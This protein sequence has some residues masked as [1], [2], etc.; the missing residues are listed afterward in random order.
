LRTDGMIA[1]PKARIPEDWP[2][3]TFEVFE[4]ATTSLRAQANS[5]GKQNDRY[6]AAYQR[7]RIVALNEDQDEFH[8]HVH[9]NVDVRALFDLLAHDSEVA[10]TVEIDALLCETL[11]S[12]SPNFTTLTLLA[13]IQCFFANFQNLDQDHGL[14][15]L[16][17]RQL[18]L[19]DG[20]FGDSE[21]A[22]LDNRKKTIFCS[23]GPVNLVDIATGRDWPFAKFI[24]AFGLRSYDT[25]PYVK[26]CRSLYYLEALKEL[27]I[28]E[29]NNSILAE[30]QDPEVFGAPYEQGRKIGHG[31]IEI[32]LEKFQEIPLIEETWL[33]IILKIA[34]DPRV[35]KG[36]RLYL[37]WWA[38]HSQREIDQVLA[39]LS[40]FDLELFLTAL[41]DYAEKS[42]DPELKRMFTAREVFL[43]GLLDHGLVKQS[44]MFLGKEAE[45]Y[46]KRNYQGEN[47]PS[48]S[49]LGHDTKSIIYLDLGFCKIIEGSHSCYFWIY[50]KL[51]S[52]QTIT[53]FSKKRFGYRE[54]TSTMGEQYCD[55]RPN[56]LSVAY[57]R[58]LPGRVMH[59]PP[60]GWQSKVI[61]I[62]KS[63]NPPIPLSA[64]KLLSTAQ[65][66]TYKNRYMGW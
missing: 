9:T 38:K 2:H 48:Y 59:N 37:K 4:R 64:E 46:I 56:I 40:G 20:S 47:I 44:R 25:S 22:K 28:E 66:L 31:I 61:K 36:S 58:T 63:L 13:A 11:E 52:S 30:I 35:P 3:Q 14:D 24:E 7:L 21:M 51:P 39:A 16:I 10:K 42:Y 34:G 62:M 26:Q 15:R 8:P 33:G 29:T 45:R 41:A 23:S 18:A 60:I 57:D 32:I 1:T 49:F 53:N 27:P 55:E 43:R 17:L 12:A 19:R 6:K 50:D 65:Y 54:L 5:V